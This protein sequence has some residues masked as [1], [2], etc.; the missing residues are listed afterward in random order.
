MCIIKTT[1][2]DFAVR[3]VAYLAF[4]VLLQFS[5][6]MI[7]VVCYIKTMRTIENVQKSLFLREQI[8]TKRLLWYPVT[9]LLIYL[10][11]Q[12][13]YFLNFCL[14]HSGRGNITNNSLAGAC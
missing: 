3:L 9:I 11:S 7:T 12:C 1:N 14:Q 13:Y 2:D 10:P 8:S 6:F 5:A 4:R